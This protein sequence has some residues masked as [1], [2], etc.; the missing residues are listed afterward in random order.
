M[1][2]EETPR[3][4][5][6]VRGKLNTLVLPDGSPITV[7]CTAHIT[8]APAVSKGKTYVTVSL[9]DT[10]VKSVRYIKAVD[11]SIRNH[12]PAL[13]YSP[14]LAQGRLLVLKILP[15]ALVDPDVHN[16]E[17]VE[18]HAKLGNFG[19]FGYCWNVNAMYR[20]STC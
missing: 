5:L 10:D 17:L 14:L 2:E 16:Q 9:K 13:E 20:H 11:D 19:K 3:F 18:F 15:K 6:S 4:L 7:K 1:C 12:Q 8:S